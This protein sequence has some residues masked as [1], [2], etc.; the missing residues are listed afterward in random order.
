MSTLRLST[1]AA[2]GLLSLALHAQVPQAISYQAVVRDP[3]SGLPMANA[4]GTVRFLLHNDTPTGPVIYGEDHPLNANDQGLF[5][6][7]IGSGIQT[8]GPFNPAAWSAV[9][10]LE[11]Q[12]DVGNTGAFT[13]M[14][15][16]QLLSVPFALRAAKSS[17]VP[18]GTEVG[19]IMHWDGT[20]W[21]ADSGL[22]VH[23][24]RF[25]I[26]VEQPESPLGVA[27]DANGLVALL[28]AK[29]TVNFTPE[30]AMRFAGPDSSGFSFS[31][32]TD[33]GYVDRLVI[34]DSTGHIGIG[35]DN[36]PSPLAIVHRNILKSFFA[37]GDKPNQQERGMGIGV[38][39]TGFGF[40]EGHLDSLQNRLFVQSGTGH[41]GLGTTDPV[42]A[43]HVRGTSGG[44][45]A[46]VSRVE[47]SAA[48]SNA[49]WGIGHLHDPSSDRDGA[50][51]LF[52]D[53]WPMVGDWDFNDAALRVLHGG[54]VGIGSS[55]PPGML[56]VGK[57][58]QLKTYFE[59][60]DIPTQDDFSFRLTDSTGFSIEQGTPTSS[61]SRLFIQ[62]NTGHVGMGTTSPQEKH[63][64]HAVHHGGHVGMRVSNG[65]VSSNGGWTLGHIDDELVPERSGAL[66][67]MEAPGSGGGA[68]GSRLVALPGGNVGINEPLPHATL[69]VTRP[70]SDP[71]EP[72]SL[73]E[74]TGIALFGPINDHI[75]L[76]HQG[77]QARH[78]LG[79]TTSVLG[80][81]GLHLQRL[82]G[83]V[84]IHGDATTDSGKSIFTDNG[85]LGL[86]TLTP[87]E[88]L[89]VNGAVVFG[90]TESASPP[91]GTIRFT[92]TDLEGR[93]NGSWASL[94]ND[95]W[96]A[97]TT[98]G[99]SFTPPGGGAMVSIGLPVPT[100]AMRVDSWASV[101]ERSTGAVF[102]NTVST[103]STDPADNRVGVQIS[104]TGLWGGDPLS[105]NIGLYISEVSGQTGAHSN[106]GAVINGNVVIGDLPTGSVVGTNGSH[107]LAIQ[108]G[109]PPASPPNSGSGLP[110]AGVQL[111][112]AGD[113]SGIS[114][115]HVMNGNGDVITL[116]RA[117][118]ITA[119]D[120]TPVD[121]MNSAATAVLI[122]NMRTRINELEN[123][124]KSLGL[125]QP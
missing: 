12:L 70:V 112:S 90:D 80:T 1:T 68:G 35:T 49:G 117:P 53:Q 41:V 69:H 55:S 3:S 43:L 40:S 39:S 101:V 36:P 30:M 37:T 7:A 98:G 25:G 87:G 116:H 15:T 125:L 56:T 74:N 17:N 78:L 75:V 104:N 48:V 92:G 42:S 5:T 2:I 82:G 120:N 33:S 4:T 86:G 110:D 26:G 105:K 6:L 38:D 62:Q 44:V 16:Q 32:V 121:P 88:R 83:D 99:I 93:K 27:A 19:Q 71:N 73:N 59:T 122:E 13:A 76:D 72:I 119:P 18:D 95:L 84:V 114:R 65:A 8:T 123:T 61:T 89:H 85:N 52:E 23:Q 54:N 106:L 109:A 67:L 81:S 34:Q 46:V 66:E 21:V 24:R 20:E 22:Y 97:G 107:V 124:L 51:V 58:D 50:F 108:N 96:Q 77:I 31:A 57:R 94:T 28:K 103:S 111:W 102:L 113:V 63:H 45:G 9:V 10:F 60:G 115:L 47:N 118:A 91:D 14:G 79:G 64:V 100:G 29:S 11:T